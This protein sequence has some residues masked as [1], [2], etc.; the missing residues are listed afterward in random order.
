MGK[1]CSQNCAMHWRV[2]DRRLTL[3]A[4]QDQSRD[5]SGLIDRQTATVLVKVSENILPIANVF[6]QPRE[7]CEA[8]EKGSGGQSW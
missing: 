4:A 5:R 1:G 6:P 8:V 3:A 7:L 2:L